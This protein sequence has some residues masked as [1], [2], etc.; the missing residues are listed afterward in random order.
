MKIENSWALWIYG[1]V[2]ETQGQGLEFI[3]T[4][5]GICCK[6]EKRGLLISIHAF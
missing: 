2:G 4:R 6:K 1:V 3:T 5:I